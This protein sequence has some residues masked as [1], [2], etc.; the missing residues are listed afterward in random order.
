[1]AGVVVPGDRPYLSFL[2]LAE[3]YCVWSTRPRNGGGVAVRL[4]CPRSGRTSGVLAILLPVGTVDPPI[5]AAGHSINVCVWLP[6]TD[7]N[8]RPSD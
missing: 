3:K 6:G 8:R 5:A 4:Y 1:M 7:S 2:M